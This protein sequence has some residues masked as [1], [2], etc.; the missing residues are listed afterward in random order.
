[1]IMAACA[2]Q[3]SEQAA[4]MARAGDVVQAARPRHG[5]V[6]FV[7]QPADAEVW[8]DR[9]PQGTCLDFAGSPKGLSLTGKMRRIEVRKEGY[10]PYE[11]YLE[12]DGTRAALNVTLTST[13]PGVA[14]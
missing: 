1:M 9:V 10:L 11:T 13:T 2:N 6:I 3:Q 5:D 8:L 4:M 14:P 7:C 12:A